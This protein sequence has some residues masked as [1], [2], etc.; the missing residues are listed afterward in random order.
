MSSLGRKRNASKK[1]LPS[2]AT[3]VTFAVNNMGQN[4]QWPSKTIEKALGL[5]AAQVSCMNDLGLDF[6]VKTGGTLVTCRGERFD[7][8]LYKRFMLSGFGNDAL[9]EK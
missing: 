6:E 2:P 8:E 3:E 1:A 5:N 9:S 4:E 7:E